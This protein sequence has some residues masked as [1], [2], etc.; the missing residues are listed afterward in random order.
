M[1]MKMQNSTSALKN[2]LAVSK[3]NNSNSNQWQNK[4]WKHHINQKLYSRHLFQR[5]ENLCPHK[6]YTWMFAVAVFVTGKHGKQPKCPLMGEWLKKLWHIHPCYPEIYKKEWTIHETT[7]W[8]SRELCWVK[9]A[10]LKR[11]HTIWFFLCNM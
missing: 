11:L 3:I 8:I 1:L 5:N 4:I 7:G 2:S 10:S 9:K 6:T